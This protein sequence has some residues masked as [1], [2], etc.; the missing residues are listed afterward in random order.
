MMCL[1]MTEFGG[2]SLTESRSG[3]WRFRDLKH[4][5]SCGAS[6]YS[7]V[8]RQATVGTIKSVFQH[9]LGIKFD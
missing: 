8:K 2:F 9:D 3:A 5:A 7:L 4:V 1:H 6:V